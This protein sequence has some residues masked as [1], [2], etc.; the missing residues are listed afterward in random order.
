MFFFYRDPYFESD[1]EDQ[2]L[3]EET[4]KPDLP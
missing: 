3:V 4:E 2:N 1:D